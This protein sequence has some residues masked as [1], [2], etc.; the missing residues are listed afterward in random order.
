MTEVMPRNDTDG[1]WKQSFHDFLEWFF[2]LFFPKVHADVDWTR[3]PEFLELEL[4][5]IHPQSETGRRSVDLLVRVWRKNGAEQWMLIH[6]EIQSQYD[7]DFPFRM[8]VYHYKILDRYKRR[9]V[10][11]AVLADDDPNWKPNHWGQ[12]L[13][14]C[15][16]NFRFP[17][18][19]LMDLAKDE[20]ALEQSDNPFAVI[21]LAHFARCGRPNILTFAGLR[22]FG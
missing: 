15:E 1:A 21:V 18:L 5:Q 8:F 4:Q 12:E 16:L 22:R 3:P 14:D 7:E 19:K 2:K 20:A 6:I 13:W 10:S 11:F 17:I 9:V